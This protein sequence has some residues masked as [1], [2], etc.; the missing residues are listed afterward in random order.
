MAENRRT[1][2]IGRAGEHYVAAELNRRGAYASPFS[3]NV[4]GIDI[5]ATDR[6]QERTLFIQVKTKRKGNWPLSLAH[7]WEIP[8]PNPVCLCL[9]TCKP[10]SCK[11]D[12]QHHLD[13]KDLGQL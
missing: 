11:D 12:H 5:V 9:G 4:P 2:T 13:A 7:G 6:R 8:T 3:G 10:G 1:D